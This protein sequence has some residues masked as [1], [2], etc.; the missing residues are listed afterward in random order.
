[1]TATP[2]LPTHSRPRMGAVR[3]TTSTA[4]LGHAQTC[5]PPENK[6]A[7]HSDFMVQLCP[8]PACP[9]LYIY[10]YIYCKGN[11][12]RNRHNASLLGRLF[13]SAPSS[14]S[15]SCWSST[16]AQARLPLII[17]TLG[18]D[19]ERAKPPT[20]SLVADA[21]CVAVVVRYSAEAW[22]ELYR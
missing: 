22:L 13:Y 11:S 14:F 16:R 18:H 21:G 19:C 6:L 17:M 10:I 8:S 1:M 3:N 5:P 2:C 20:M 4:R 7:R 9:L 12:Q 15:S